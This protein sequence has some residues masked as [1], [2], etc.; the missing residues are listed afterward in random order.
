MLS[1]DDGLMYAFSVNV[2]RDARNIKLGNQWNVLCK[3]NDFKDG[4]VIRFKFDKDLRCHVFK[5]KY[6]T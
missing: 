2:D 1:A 5:T 6:Y 3:N 4:D